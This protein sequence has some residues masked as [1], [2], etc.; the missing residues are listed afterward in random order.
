MTPESQL[1]YIF[2]G[3]QNAT[4]HE[5]QFPG[6]SPANSHPPEGVEHCD[7]GHHRA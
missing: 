1:F 5:L 2:A 6:E 4:I 3:F 7:E